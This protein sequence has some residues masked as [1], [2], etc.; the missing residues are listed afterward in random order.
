MRKEV[1][2][3]SWS[4]SLARI[5][6]REAHREKRRRPRI[7]SGPPA[8]FGR[9]LYNTTWGTEGSRARRSRT[10]TV[11]GGTAIYEV[12]PSRREL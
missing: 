10:S 11:R 3:P 1:A 8:A 12:V 5:L 9:R 4:D 6:G 7:D 2:P